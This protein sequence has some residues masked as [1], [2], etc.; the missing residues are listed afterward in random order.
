MG[1]CK[2]A[3]YN[4]SNSGL[5]PA[6]QWLMEHITDADFDSEFVVPGTENIRQNFVPD[7]SGI[8]MLMGMGFNKSQATKALKETGNNIE[9]AVDYIFSHPDDLDELPMAVEAGPAAANKNY[10]DGDSR[11]CF[12]FKMIVY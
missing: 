7:P 12:L 3:I 10:R 8:D 11:K 5:E 6:T 2:R 9:R 1:A 4:T